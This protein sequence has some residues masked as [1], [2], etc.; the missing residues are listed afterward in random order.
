MQNIINLISSLIKRKESDINNWFEE[1]FKN[2]KPPFYSSVDL[3]NSGYKIAPVDVN[4]FPAGYNNLNKESQTLASEL[5]QKYLLKYKKVLI[6]PENHTRNTNYIANLAALKNIFELAGIEAYVHHK[7]LDSAFLALK[8][9]DNLLIT[10]A[11]FMPDLIVINNDMT[12]GIPEALE[13]IKQD[14]IPS[15]L[16]GWHNRNKSRYFEIY[17][18]VIL[19]FCSEFEL[20][21]WLISAYT[22]GCKNIDFATNQGLEAVAAAVDDMITKIKDKFQVYNIKEQ[23]YVLI[24]ADK[25]TYGMGIMTVTSAED[26]LQINKKNRNKMNKIKDGVKVNS[27]IVQEGVPTLDR[28]HGGAAEPLI[29]YVGGCPVCYLFRYNNNKDKYSNLNSLGCNFIDVSSITEKKTLLVW[30]LISKLAVLAAAKESR[31]FN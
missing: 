3:R 21:E 16:L 29:Y 8:K 11:G 27:V 22:T 28:F 25:G 15:P 12:G 18:N 10:E 24:K 4:L 20:D 6:L 23:P 26:I 1:S 31:S 7:N 13:N 30:S 19:E 5:V 14:I 2:F 9:D 17:K